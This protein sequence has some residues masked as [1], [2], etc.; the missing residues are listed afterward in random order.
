MRKTYLAGTLVIAVLCASCSESGEKK[1][2][3][4]I[5]QSDTVTVSSASPV[6]SKLKLETVGTEPFS[7][8]FRTVGTVRAESGRYAEV[9]VPFDGRILNTKVRIGS[10]VR[11]GQP[12]FEMS[13]TEFMETVKDYFQSLRTYEKALAEYNRKQSLQSSGIVS[14]KDM[15]EAFVEAEN[16]RQDKECAESAIKVYGMDLSSLS[17]G[18]P[19]TVSAPI[20]GEVVSYSLTPGSFVRADADAVMTIADLSKVWISAQV[21]EHFIGSVGLGAVTEIYTDSS[22]GRQM[23]GKVLYVGNIVDEQ[24]RTVQVIVEC[25]NADRVLKH[26][27]FVSVHFMDEARESVLVPA[28]AV[29]QGDASSYVYVATDSPG[30]FV[31]RKVTT[32]PENPGKT[33][34]LI[35][36]GLVE[37]ETIVAEGGLYLN[38]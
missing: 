22:K 28:T 12:L 31:R 37:G 9:G 19:L 21:K 7:S 36:E 8:E 26:G 10:V 24:T 14:Q 32:G 11:A 6:I 16:A 27:M 18:R 34:I 5:Y 15:E 20:G 38:N 17:V 33:R 23:L 4:I 3:E 13:S 2:E 29:F 30:C 1:T 35:E 25:D